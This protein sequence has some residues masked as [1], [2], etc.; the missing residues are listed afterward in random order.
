MRY[1]TTNDCV[2]ENNLR[3]EYTEENKSVGNDEYGGEVHEDD[4]PPNVIFVASLPAACESPSL[5]F[6]LQ[7]RRTEEVFD[8]DDTEGR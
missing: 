5:P 7:N 4:L 8:D 2:E 3:I 6:K 1:G